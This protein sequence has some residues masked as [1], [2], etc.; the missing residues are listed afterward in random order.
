MSSAKKLTKEESVKS[1]Q[2]EVNKSKTLRVA[3]KKCV[4]EASST[5][6]FLYSLFENLFF[7]GSINLFQNV[8]WSN[9]SKTDEFQAWTHGFIKSSQD[10]RDGQLKSFEKLRPILSRFLVK[11]K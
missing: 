10:F 11:G 9:V 8:H 7:G 5:S 3:L 6:V 2:N 4:R 1:F